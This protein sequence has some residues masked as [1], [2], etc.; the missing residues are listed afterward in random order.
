MAGSVGKYYLA[1]FRTSFPLSQFSNLANANQ[2]SNYEGIHSTALWSRILAS[3]SLDNS[4]S[5]FH[6]RSELGTN[7]R[8]LFNTLHFIVLSTSLCAAANHIFTLVGCR[9][10]AL[11]RIYLALSG[12]SNLAHSIHTSSLFSH[13]Y[14][15]QARIFLAA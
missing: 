5:S 9:L 10:A 2:N 13:Y 7:S 11:A 8:A 3:Y 1:L 12:V 6:S 14:N 4:I 15:P